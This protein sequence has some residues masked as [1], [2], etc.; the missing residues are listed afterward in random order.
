MV[1][2]CYTLRKSYL[3]KMSVMF[4]AAPEELIYWKLNWNLPVTASAVTMVGPAE[5]VI[6]AAETLEAV[7]E[8]A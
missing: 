1:S 6:P 7:S 3:V 5:M 8:T 4:L 2:P